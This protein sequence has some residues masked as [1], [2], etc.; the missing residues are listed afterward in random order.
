MEDNKKRKN[1]SPEFKAEA[2]KLAES[3]S[4]S[5]ASKELGVS[6][7]SLRIWISRSANSRKPDPSRPSYSELEKEIRRLKRENG[8]LEKINTILKKSTAILSQD[9]MGDLK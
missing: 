5:N 1:Y 2:V 3:T 9:T 7:G 6:L 8:Y 4:L